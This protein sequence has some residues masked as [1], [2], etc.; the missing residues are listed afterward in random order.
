M[1]SRIVDNRRVSLAD[2]INEIAPDFEE[3]SIATGYWDLHGMGLLMASLAKFKRVRLLIGQEPLSPRLAS[4][5][6]IYEPESLFPEREI[7]EGLNSLSFDP[8]L[9]DLVTQIR[10]LLQNGVLEVRVYRETFLHAKAYIFGNYESR[11][12]QGI[13]GSS[14]FTRAGLTTNLELNA[15]EEDERI[16]KFK[17]L[18]EHDSHGHLSWFD[19]LWDSPQTEAWDGKFTELLEASPVG[20][21]TFSK[22]LMYIK[23]LYEIYSDELVEENDLSHETDEV[24]FD[25]QKRNARLLLAKLEKHGLAMLADSVGLGKTITAGAVMRHYIEERDARRVYVIAPASLTYQW[26]DDLAKVHQLFNGFEVISM[27]DVARIRRERQIDKY[28]GVDLFVVDEAHNLRSGS[29]SRHDEILEWFS[30]NQESHVLLLTATPINNSLSDFANQIQLAAKGKL[31]SFPVVYPASKKTEVIDFYEAVARLSKEITEAEK[32]GTKPDYAKINRVMQQGLRRFLVRTTRRGIER[33]FG[34]IA[35]SSGAVQR[36][37]ESEV[38][39]SPYSFNPELTKAIDERL[40]RNADA[41]RGWEPARLSIPWLLAQTQRAQHPLDFLTEAAFSADDRKIDASAFERIFQVLLLLGFAPYKADIYHKRFYGKTPEEIRSFA[42]KPEDSMRVNSQLSVHNML[43]VTLLKRLESSQYALKRS[44]QNYLGKLSEFSDFLD[45]GFLPRFRDLGDLRAT[46]G[47][48]LDSLSEESLSEATDNDLDIV[49]IDESVLNVQALRRDVET[50]VQIVRILIDLCDTLGAQDDKLHAFAQMVK[51]IVA[52]QGD[53][54]KILVFS[55]YADTIDYLRENVPA[56][57]GGQD[58]MGRAAF[59]SGKNKTQIEDVARRF[60]PKS[61]G[62]ADIKPEDELNYLFSTDVLS[63]G[64]NLQ[65]CG[66]L[67]NFDLHWNPVRMIQRNGRI[68]RLGSRHSKV[69]IQNMHPEVNLEEYLAL[70]ARLEIK[71]DRIRYTVGTDQSV[72]GEDA[73]PIEFIDEIEAAKVESE[74]LRM[75]DPQVASRVLNEF[76]DD[77]DLLSEDEF[78]LDLRAFERDAPQAQ[79]DAVARIPIGKWGF[80]PSHG[81]AELGDVQAL[82]LLR[83]SGTNVGDETEFTNHIFV[84]TTDSWGPVETIDALRALRV[85]PTALEMTIDDIKLDRSL[86]SQRSKQ[87]AKSHVK[88]A[89]SGYRMT[90]STTRALDEVNRQVPELDLHSSL[91]RVSTKIELRRAKRLVE[92]VNKDVKTYGV[93]LDPTVA[94]VRGFCELMLTR[95]APARL[96][97]QDGVV[98]VLFYAR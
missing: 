11:K 5:L 25:F 23:T 35:D 77:E 68:N 17:P 22:Y 8:E 37:P 51:K 54:T 27:Q 52:E 58:F 82:A 71:I 75:Y 28:A 49:P 19:E 41:F 40:G 72:L 9:R 63:E 15:V 91:A 26:R 55:Y 7:A 90:P 59:T 24:L 66:V 47:D 56:L 86:I 10:E 83:V 33:E 18:G 89:A 92:Q 74:L 98:G 4:N 61:K 21:R 60:S 80:L 69:I 45:R 34:G 97:D 78:I 95:E 65:D 30:D 76:D 62:Y 29:G 36:F 1:A 38:V 20:D 96:I 44:L 39:P 67:I 50:D 43:R 93:V 64:Q 94:L 85:P 14:N 48:D 3:L 2:V 53:K 73:N 88:T 70:V 31:E 84:S 57:L 81:K 79:R 16:V 87:V 13:I 32:K 42:L 12:A 6:N 46:Y